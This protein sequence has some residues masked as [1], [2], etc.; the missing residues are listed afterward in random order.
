MLALGPVRAERLEPRRLGHRDDRFT[1]Q[2]L[3]VLAKN[4]WARA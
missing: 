3:G 1:K 4:R 2:S